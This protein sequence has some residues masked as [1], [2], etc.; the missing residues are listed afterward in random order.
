MYVELNG[1]QLTLSG[2]FNG[3]ESEFDETI[4][5]G[6][7][8]HIAGADANGGVDIFL[9]ALLMDD[10]SNGVFLPMDNVNSI[11]SGQLGNLMAESY[12]VNIHTTA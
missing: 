8:L 5:G 4:A 7:H 10:S 1:N 11:D 6:A 2:S 9:N 3:L 12:Y